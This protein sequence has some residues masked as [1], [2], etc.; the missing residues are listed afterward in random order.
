MENKSKF[1]R[2]PGLNDVARLAGVSHQTVSRVVNNQPRVSPETRARV[3]LAIDQ[4]QYRR[5]NAARTLVTNRSG[6]L[7]VIAVG[8]AL[9]GPTLT[10]SALEAAAREHGYMTLIATLRHGE[11]EA[12]NQA[13]E[14][15]L[16]QGV[17]A[18]VIVASR[19]TLAQLAIKLSLEVPVFV[20]GPRASESSSPYGIGFDQV[21]GGRIAAEHLIGQGHHDVL[22]LTGPLEWVA[23][24]DRFLG[25]ETACAELGVDGSRIR[26]GDWS[27]QS[28]YE[29]GKF[30]AAANHM[31]TGIFAA[32][33]HM[34]LGL[35]HACHDFGIKVPQELSVIGFDDVSGADHFHP[36]LTTVRKD[37][38][39]L[40]THVLQAV[41][42]VLE[43]RDPDLSTLSPTL[44]I[45]ASTGPPRESS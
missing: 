27:A 45:R 22:H 30:L 35:L 26:V 24:R 41:I 2:P 5:N 44:T 19:S 34:A 4:L 16:R 17:E 42:A 11:P 6:L 1:R 3:Q 31:P 33:D 18:L 25:W 37:S 23:A 15:C 12:L 20:V 43:G 32:N 39:T 14:S 28:G 36:P 13:I 8:S 7:G 9:V 21:L 40:G 38:A 29:T 10:M